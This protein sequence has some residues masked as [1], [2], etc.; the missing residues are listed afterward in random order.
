MIQKENHFM[1]KLLFLI[2]MSS[3]VFIGSVNI[4][5]ACAGKP[6]AK[7]AQ[8]HT[9]PCEKCLNAGK[10]CT[11][12]AGKTKKPCEKVL[13]KEKPCYKCQQSEQKPRRTN[14]TNIFFNE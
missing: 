9:K 2:A 6:C 13:D 14:P 11:K 7:C 1:K 8:S 12:C 3:F 5:S 4:A 10:P